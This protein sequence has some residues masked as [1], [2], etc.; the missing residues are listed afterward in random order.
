[1]TGQRAPRPLPLPRPPPR[2]PRLR[3]PSPGLESAAADP[4]RRRKGLRRGAPGS[5]GPGE[6]PPAASCPKCKAL[7]GPREERGRP[8]SPALGRPAALARAP[9]WPPTPHPAAARPGP[10]RS[11]GRL[12]V[13][14]REAGGRASREAPAAEVLDRNPGGGSRGADTRV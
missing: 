4:T 12:R 3:L 2:S 13:L 8:P 5:Q 14:E 7:T 11:G 6:G 1:M 10:L 9:A